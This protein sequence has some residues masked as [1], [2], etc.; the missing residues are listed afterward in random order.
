MPSSAPKNMARRH[1]VSTVH[2]QIQH[3]ISAAVCPKAQGHGAAYDPATLHLRA[4]TWHEPFSGLPI[5][6]SAR[7]SSCRRAQLGYRPARNCRG[8]TPAL[9]KSVEVSLGP[10]V[11][12]EKHRL[13]I[14]FECLHCSFYLP[15]ARPA[16]KTPPEESSTGSRRA[17]TITRDV[18]AF[19]NFTRGSDWELQ[20]LAVESRTQPM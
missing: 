5:F 16:I 20:A 9:R 12:Y 10:V 15:A 1:L 13:P 19:S 6:S 11:Q 7:A 3:T 8:E 2:V 4:P 14:P 18:S 17:L